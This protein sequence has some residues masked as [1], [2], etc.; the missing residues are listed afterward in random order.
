ME[1]E[2]SKY[3]IGG[4]C[5]LPDSI[6]LISDYAFSGCT[7]LTSIEIPN[8]VTEIGKGA[9]FGC[10]GLTSI[11]IPDSVTKIGESAF[12][13][14]TGLTSIEIPDS[15]TLIGNV[16]LCGCTG[17]EGIEVSDNNQNYCSVN[18]CCLTNDG[19]TLIFGCKTSIIPDSVT[20]IS[21]HAFDGCTELRTIEIPDSVTDIDDLAF[22]GCTGLEKIE[23][24]DNNPNYRSENNCCLTKDGRTLVFGCKASSIPDSVTEIG[25]FA[26]DGRTGLISIE[27][28][29]SVT[30]I[31]VGAFNSCNGLSAIEIPV[32]VTEIGCF[33][34]EL[35]TGLISIEIPDTVT[36]IGY[37]AFRGCNGLKQV[38]LNISKKKP[39]ESESFINRVLDE[40][41]SHVKLTVHI[42]IGTGYAYRHYPKFDQERLTFV[43][44]NK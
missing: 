8:S 20:K 27:I 1:K 37:F 32:S 21:A 44:C 22:I 35:C 5:V 11:E 31:E 39:S 38:I 6:T 18:N 13:D 29:N 12:I 9:F 3:I 33:A 10:S 30:K 24:S 17:L 42:P 34:F 15:V 26:F 2:Y 40:L 23:V 16:A 43:P 4:K 19:E 36:E 28:P 41:D 25:C 7:W 14:C